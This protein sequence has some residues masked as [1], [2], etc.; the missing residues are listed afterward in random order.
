[1]EKRLGQKL[2]SFIGLLVFGLI[3]FLGFYHFSQRFASEYSV[4]N[5]MKQ[6]ERPD[7][8][9]RETVVSDAAKGE[10]VLR[11][12]KIQS[13]GEID[14]TYRGLTADSK[15]LV[16]VIIPQLDPQ[17][18]YKHSLDIHAARHG[19]RMAGSEYKLDSVGE[20]YIRLIRKKP[21]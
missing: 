14:I 16:E 1:M 21:Q 11:L 6:R 12:N 7:T 19:F 15:F 5:V 17:R 20:N 8:F 10:Y 13:I 3:V 9:Y 2:I 4:H 18:P